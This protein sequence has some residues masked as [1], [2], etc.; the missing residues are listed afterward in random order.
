MNKKEKGKGVGEKK[1]YSTEQ[2]N[3]LIREGF[4][5]LDSIHSG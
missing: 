4:L 1:N 2:N 3:K 5:C